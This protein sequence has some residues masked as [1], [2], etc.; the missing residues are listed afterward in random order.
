[1]CA[2]V[3]A[4]GA[5]IVGKTMLHTFQMPAKPGASLAEAS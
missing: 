3:L 2:L 4:A 1:L 5:F